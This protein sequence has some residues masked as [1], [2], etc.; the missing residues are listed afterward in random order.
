MWT[1]R[2]R[3]P[4][5]VLKGYWFESNLGSPDPG[6]AMVAHPRLEYFRGM[7]ERFTMPPCHGVRYGFESRYLGNMLMWRNGSSHAHNLR[8]VG[9]TPT[10]A[11]K[12]YGA[13]VKRQSQNSHKVLF[14]VR[15][16]VALQSV[17]RPQNRSSS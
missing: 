11:T 15:V 4:L 14:Q 2:V 9:S 13:M 8:I 10:V 16:L 3:V 6:S 12:I 7:V 17:C 1:V 5:V